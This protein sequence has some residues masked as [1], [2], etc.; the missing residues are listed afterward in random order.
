MSLGIRP[1]PTRLDRDLE[2]YLLSLRA[3]VEKLQKDMLALGGGG[4]GG[5]GTTGMR[6]PAGPKGSDANVA[7]L[8]YGVIGFY[9]GQPPSLV[10][11]ILYVAAWA[12]RFDPA[13]VESR[14]EALTAATADTDFEVAINLRPVGHFHFPAGEKIGELIAVPF[15]LN[16]DDIL[17]V[18]APEVPDATLADVTFTVAGIRIDEPTGVVNLL[19]D[20][21]G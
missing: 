4:S 18:K 16:S 19:P 3:A 1:V 14:A 11:I 12:A 8:P 7:N 17:T 9:P 15:I 5:E 10:T 13:N 6:G 21:V 20:E 2:L